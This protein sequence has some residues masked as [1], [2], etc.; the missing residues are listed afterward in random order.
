MSFS[1]GTSVSI[2]SQ[3]VSAS[4]KGLSSA[5]LVAAGSPQTAAVSAAI[6][7]RIITFYLPPIW[8]GVA[9]RSLRKHEYI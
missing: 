8:G 9:M 3:V 1:G 4:M 5:G 2:R 6:M 7:F